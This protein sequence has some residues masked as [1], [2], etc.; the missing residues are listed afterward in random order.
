MGLASV[1]FLRSESLELPNFGLLSC[2]LL[3][4]PLAAAE[5]SAFTSTFPALTSDFCAF[6]AGAEI[7]TAFFGG[8]ANLTEGVSNS[9]DAFLSA[10]RADFDSA[11][12][13]RVWVRL[14]R[15]EL[16]DF[17]GVDDFFVTFLRA[18]IGQVSRNARRARLPAIMNA[19]PLG[20]D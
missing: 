7:F 17:G 11:V 3:T 18:A 9:E 15:D 10:G 13:P 19:T 5:F 1:E 14:E 6:S 2:A 4:A 12:W 20:K 8:A 16:L